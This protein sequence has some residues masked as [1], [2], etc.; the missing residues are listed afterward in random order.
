MKKAMVTVLALSMMLAVTACSDG[1]TTAGDNTGN[2]TDAE[3]EAS[4][5]SHGEDDSDKEDA[6]SEEEETTEDV[7]AVPE[8]YVEYE[9][10]NELFG[11]KCSF[12]LPELNGWTETDQTKYPNQKRVKYSTEFDVDGSTQTCDVTIIATIDSG[13]SL[14]FDLK[15]NDPIP[16]TQYTGYLTGT[17]RTQGCPMVLFGDEYL[18][19]LVQVKASIEC[20]TEDMNQADYEAVVESVQKS[21]QIETLDSNELYTDDGSLKNTRGLFVYP[22]TMTIQ[23]NDATA[24]YTV[25]SGDAWIKAEFTDEGQNVYVREDGLGN[26]ASFDGYL[27]SNEKNQPYECEVAGYPARA[28]L[29]NETERVNGRYIIKIDDE[30]YYDLVVS[31]KGDMDLETVMSM[32]EGAGRKELQDKFTAYATDFMESAVTE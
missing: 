26:Q 27:D 21:L 14:E 11:I 2:T 28:Y 5:D 18:D 24:A 8:G 15:T 9:V 17:S 10:V 23:G 30:T 20:M 3:I 13:N 1:G 25:A 32:M 31:S 29:F 19:G 4:T 12:Q 16:N 22:T 6:A 7:S